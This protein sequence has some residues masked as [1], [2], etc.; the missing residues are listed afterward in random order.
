MMCN[1]GKTHRNSLYGREERGTGSV[2]WTGTASV[3]VIS[4]PSDAPNGEKPTAARLKTPNNTLERF[5]RVRHSV[6]E[7]DEERNLGREKS[8]AHD[9]TRVPQR[10]SRNDHNLLARWC[11]HSKEHPV[12]RP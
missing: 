7:G 9:G 1:N 3:S 10:Q 12:A 11:C 4:R 6:P 2:E 5:G 8:K